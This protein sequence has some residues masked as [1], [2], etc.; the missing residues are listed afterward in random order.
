MIFYHTQLELAFKPTGITRSDER[1]PTVLST[2]VIKSLAIGRFA[3]A[4]QTRL[5]RLVYKPTTEPIPLDKGSLVL[6]SE[7]TPQNYQSALMS[8]VERYFR[9]KA[10]IEGTSAAFGV[11]PLFVWQP[12]PLYKYDLTYH[13]FKSDSWITPRHLFSR[14]G[15][16]IM[17]N[18]VDNRRPDKFI[19]CADIQNDIREPLYVDLLHYSPKMIDMFAACIVDGVHRGVGSTTNAS[20]GRVI[21]ATS[22]APRSLSVPGSS[23]SATVSMR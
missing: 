10:M 20:M 14:D 1:K 22:K 9:N 5:Q 11:R 8:V 4:I 12:T 2:E 16:P 7:D 15:Y 17:R 21:P 6:N 3:Q 19:W 23:P 13:L 18:A